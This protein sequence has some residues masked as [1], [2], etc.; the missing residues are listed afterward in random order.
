MRVNSGL[1]ANRKKNRRPGKKATWRGR[2][3]LMSKYGIKKEFN[4]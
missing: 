3:S 2:K 1:I 4:A